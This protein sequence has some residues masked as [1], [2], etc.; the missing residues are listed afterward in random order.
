VANSLAA[1]CFNRDVHEELLELGL[2]APDGTYRVPNAAIRQ[3]LNIRVP[4]NYR[5]GCSIEPY[6][7][8]RWYVWRYDLDRRT[9][10]PSPAARAGAELAPARIPPA[11]PASSE[12]LQSPPA[13]PPQSLPTEPVLSPSE[14]SATREPPAED[15]E[16]QKLPRLPE[17]PQDES[18]KWRP[19]EAKTWLENAMRTHPLKEGQNK[20]AYAR[21]LYDRMKSDFGEDI[22]WGTWETLRRR[23]DD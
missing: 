19:N 11:E 3:E 21:Q 10:I 4:L 6:Y 23:M 5:E 15:V 8:G 2:V 20:N 13:E 16:Q 14:P 9:T 7:E 12:A 17:E 18:R 22:P 1:T